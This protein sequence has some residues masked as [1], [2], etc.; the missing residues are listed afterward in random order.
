[1]SALPHVD[2]DPPVH[3]TASDGLRSYTL[4]IAAK[5]ERAVRAGTLPPINDDERRQRA[6]GPR[7][8]SELDC[9]REVR[10]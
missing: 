2:N 10:A 1:M 8:W 4:A 6:E 3:N 7:G 9:V 5:R